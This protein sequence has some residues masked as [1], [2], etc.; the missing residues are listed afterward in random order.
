MYK[1]HPPLHKKEK[2]TERSKVADFFSIVSNIWGD[3][4]Q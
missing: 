4:A 3:G 2:A 1:A